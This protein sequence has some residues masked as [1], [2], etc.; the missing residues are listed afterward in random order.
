MSAAPDVLAKCPALMV[1]RE[2]KGVHAPTTM[3]RGN[4]RRRSV[5]LA[6]IALIC[7]AVT[8]M[9]DSAASTDSE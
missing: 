2:V 6:V 7:A 9:T 5:P 4:K 3:H 8:P 1:A